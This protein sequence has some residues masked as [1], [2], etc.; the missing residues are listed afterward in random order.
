MYDP[1]ARATQHY[2]IV[3]D[4]AQAPSSMS[5]LETLQSYPSQ[6]KSLLSAIRGIDPTDSNLIYFD[7]ENHVLCLPHRI[8]FLIK[9]IINENTIHRTV[10]D[11][12]GSTYIM[13]ITCCKAIGSPALNQSPNTLEAFDGRDSRPFGVLPNLFITL[14]GKTMQVELEIVDANLNYN[15]LLDQR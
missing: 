12:G 13:S 14:E 2:N 6:Q 4:L 7:V 8:P 10:I 5:A 11:E 3:E 1:N 9:V 15:L